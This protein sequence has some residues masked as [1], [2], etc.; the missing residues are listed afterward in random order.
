M[1]LVGQKQKKQFAD[2]GAAAA[3]VEESFAFASHTSHTSHTGLYHSSSMSH[4]KNK[5]QGGLQFLD[6][7]AANLTKTSCSKHG[8]AQGVLGIWRFVAPAYCGT[9]THTH[10][11]THTRTNTHTNTHTRALL[12]VGLSML[13]APCC[14]A[15]VKTKE[16]EERQRGIKMTRKMIL[17]H[18]CGTCQ[19]K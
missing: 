11:H 4:G 12:A 6:S 5:G 15:L 9:H 16:R 3:W 19:V 17:K 2:A 18:K 7:Q 10:T 8:K 13:H 1:L 14:C